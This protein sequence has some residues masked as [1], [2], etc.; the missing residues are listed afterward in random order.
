MSKRRLLW[1]PHTSWTQCKAQRPWFLIRGLAE[2][3][4][5]HIATWAAR[6][7]KAG[8]SYYANPAN[9]VRALQAGSEACE[10]AQVHS[11]GVPLPVLRGLIKGYPPDAV[12]APA[13]WRF[14][15][16][17][18]KLHRKWRFDAMV[19]SA[20]HH[21]TGYPPKL[22]GVPCV[23]D[24]VDTSPEHVEAHY[25]RNAA[26]VV[27]VSRFLQERLSRLYG[28]ESEWIPNGLEFER[29]ARGNRER[30]RAQWGLEGKTV[31]SLIGLTCS[32][33]LYF[34][35]ALASLRHKIP[36]LIFVAAGGGGIAERIAAR[37]AQLDL[38]TV[39]TGWLEHERVPDLFAASDVGLYP[40]DENIYYDGACPLKVIEY[41]GQG[42]PMVA[43]H[44][45]ELQRLG[46]A[47]MELRAA[48][49]EAFA[50]GIRAALKKPRMRVAGIEAFDWAGLCGKFAAVIER[51]QVLI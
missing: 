9:L 26:A 8:R 48:T 22:R 38:P 5:I 35:E 12:M 6:P 27:A 44:S 16:N 51:A 17:I 50:D 32:E 11:M 30:G 15:S 18:R 1:I 10:F 46:F 37:A 41:A 21:F 13:Q 45:A 43:S 47:N 31:V 14:Q 2:K 19:A 25:V 42:V 28:R 24:Y 33:R 7:P 40:G 3:F 39:M 29:I 34:L 36:N 20:S 49:A 23:F 4:E